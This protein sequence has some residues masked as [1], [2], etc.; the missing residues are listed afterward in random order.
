MLS[1]P[2]NAAM[3]NGVI[4]GTLV[5]DGDGTVIVTLSSLL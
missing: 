4:T 3:P 5:A 2:I 1:N